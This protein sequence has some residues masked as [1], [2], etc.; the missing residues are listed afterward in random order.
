M[1][2]SKR[3]SCWRIH[4]SGLSE[5]IMNGRSP[6]TRNGHDKRLASAH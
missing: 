6:N 2:A 5:A 4:T 3:N 1:V